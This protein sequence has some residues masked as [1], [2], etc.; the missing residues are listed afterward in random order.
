MHVIDAL[1]FGGAERM[2]VD[3]ANATAADGHTVSVSLTRDGRD[4]ANGLRPDVR[5]SVLAR[6]KRLD[7]AA[8]KQ[9]ASIVREERVDILHVH[10]RTTFAF[11]A[12][13]KA[14]GWVSTPILLHDHH[15]LIE[16]DS[17]VPLW[18]R[19]WGRH[20]VERYVGVYSRL[21]EW[22]VT[23]GVPQA[24]T[25]AIGNAIDLDR[26]QNA[27]PVNLR[28][29]FGI[30]EHE[31]I[32]IVVCGI[33]REKGI[34][35][36]LEALPRLCQRHAL[37]VLLVGGEREAGH[38]A[39]CKSKACSLGLG[40]SVI[41]AGER[42]D[43]ARLMKGADFGVI[44]SLSESGPLVLIEMMA[45]G[46]PFV[47][48]LVGDIAHRVKKLGGTQFIPP[49]DPAAMA[50]ALD[51]LLALPPDTWKARV[52]SGRR[53]AR[54]QFD[55]RHAMPHWYRMYRECLNPITP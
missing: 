48:T 45:A 49:G 51:R 46:L 15:G 38:V 6:K 3:I 26:L 24:R 13:V 16:I 29:E 34:L 35:Q 55:V 17:S 37:Q 33:R 36:L 47:A 39:V 53:L 20:Y 4:L 11:V 40:Q 14:L 18:F 31:R 42:S 7:W 1:R 21:A 41:F 54:E 12:L 30:A 10:G 32:G 25:C 9:F 28:V 50:E 8:L 43:V 44:P 23:A 27:L 52:E 2:L 5:L 19:L 22:A